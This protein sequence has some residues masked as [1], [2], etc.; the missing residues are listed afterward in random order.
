MGIEA[1]YYNQYTGITPEEYVRKTQLENPKQVE[2]AESIARYIPD[3][4]TSVL[5]VGCG[6]GLALNAIGQRRPDIKRVGLE[7]SEKTA[8]AARN[9]FGLDVVDGSADALPFDDNTFDVVMA[10]EILEHLPW[11]VYENTLVELARVAKQTILI[12][13][14]YREKRQFVTCPKCA[15]S[16]S[17]FYH[18]RS[19]N[20]DTL[21]SLFEGF[22]RVEQDLMWVK[23]QTPLLYEARRLK[24]AMG[25]IPPLPRHTICP[26]CGYR[27][28]P[29]ES[30]GQ[31]D[32]VISTHKPSLLNRAIVGAW[33][34]IPRPKR[35]KWAI[36]RYAARS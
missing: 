24:A 7:R 6:G 13:T 27:N 25:R 2:R 17:P 14:P 11:R 3:D 32:A 31:P 28:Q 5:D 20:D 34:L 30:V 36:V 33:G 10:N 1:E 16:F 12:T 21:G 4:A 8:Q 19:F 22:D 23:G 35:A 18:I 15:C 26:Q 29:K 9:L